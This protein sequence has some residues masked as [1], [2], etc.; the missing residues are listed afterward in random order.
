MPDLNEKQMRV[1]I[2]RIARKSK[3][4]KGGKTYTSIGLQVKELPNTWINGFGDKSNTNWKEGDVMD[5]VIFDHE[6]NGNVTKQFKPIDQYELRMT[7]LKS[8]ITK[9]NPSN[10]QKFDEIY[11]RTDMYKDDKT[12][13]VIR[14]MYT[15]VNSAPVATPTSNLPF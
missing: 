9:M 15:L 6:Y 11:N 5:L 2:T 3:T 1:T 7:A 13:E 12:M 14:L 8:V 4:S 10:A